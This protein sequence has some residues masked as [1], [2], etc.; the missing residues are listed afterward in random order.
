MSII[1][2]HCEVLLGIFPEYKIQKYAE[3][4]LKFLWVWP[5]K[6]SLWDSMMLILTAREILYTGPFK[7][8][9]VKMPPFLVEQRQ[10]GSFL[11]IIFLGYGP[12]IRA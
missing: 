4:Q 11:P 5:S 1:L 8:N 6:T 2:S 7:W 3:T 9:F 10:S 12:G